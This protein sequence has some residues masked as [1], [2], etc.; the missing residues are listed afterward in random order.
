[1]RQLRSIHFFA[2]ILT[3][4]LFC[5]ASAVS[6]VAQNRV[7]GAISNSNRVPLR[8]NTRPLVKQ[9]EDLGA[10][11][12][13]TKLPSI[14]L[15]FQPSAGQQAALS[16]LLLE[17]QE[18]ASPMYHQWLTP[19]QFGA[20]FGASQHD[21]A[22]VSAW[23][24]QQGFAINAV[25]RGGQWINFAGTA[26]QAQQ[27]FG[28]ELHIIRLNGETHIANLT[29]PMIPAALAGVVSAIQGLDDFRLQP[30]SIV[31]MVS[32]DYTSSVSGSHY[33]APGDFYAI[34]DINPLLSTGINGTG[35]TIAVMGQVD[36]NL[37]DV[38][39]FR[40]VSG[41]PAN[42]PTVRLYGKD[43]GLPGTLG[44]GATTGDLTEAQLDVEWSGAVAPNASILFVNSTDAFTS[45]TNA[46]NDN[47]APILSVS[48]GNCESSFGS[49][50][51]NADN[52]LFEQA[53]AQGQS[54]VAPAG[55]SGA[56]DCDGGTDANGNPI[57]SATNGLAVDFPA[58]SP[59]VTGVGGATL[60]EGSGNYWNANNGAN[61]GSAIS[62]IP[63]VVW[64]DTNATNGL[65]A[66]GGGVSAFFAKP[67][68]QRGQ[69]VPNDFSRDVPDI[70]L[71]ASPNHDGYIICTEN[72]SKNNVDQGSSCQN[73][74]YR[75]GG[76][77][78]SIYVVGGTSAGVP[79][80]AGVLALVVQKT[81]GRIG[82]ANPIIYALA[83]TN[84]YNNI[85]HDITVGTNASP[86]TQG[87]V[88]CPNGGTLGYGATVGYDLASGWGSINAFNLA[89]TWSTASVAGIGSQ[90]LSTTTLA[91]SPVASK[92]G[93]SL[94]FTATVAPASGSG[95]PTGSVQFFLVSNGGSSNTPL[96]S[97]APLSNGTAVYSTT[98]VP[99]G[100]QT[101]GAF[102]QGDNAYG[103]SK[104]TFDIAVTS[105]SN[106][107]FSI[108]PLSGNLTAGAPGQPTNAF[109]LTFTSVN[110][111]AGKLT[112]SV[113]S[114]VNE[115]TYAFG[116]NATFNSPT[117]TWSVS[118]PANGS[119]TTT[120]T[121]GTTAPQAR[122]GP[123]NSTR[124]APPPDPRGRDRRL[125]FGAVGGGMVLAGMFLIA[126]PR[127][128][129]W[130]PLLAFGLL[131]VL[132][133]GVGC[134]GG[135]GGGGAGVTT[136]IPPNPGTSVGSFPVAVTATIAS[137]NAT[138]T[139]TANLTLVV[140]Q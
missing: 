79:S 6:A 24:Q 140:V 52:L 118:I 16:E 68:W 25:S 105:A 54:I 94:T 38:A 124:L 111:L 114:A 33:L 109:P 50:S 87:S 106:P 58:S 88:G 90:T 48:Y 20:Q 65:S 32:P 63:E 5:Q 37:A 59:Y 30:R 100:D 35:V 123:V 129:R 138:V 95:T 70:A 139:H 80:F 72:Y 8:G 4:L 13:G 83:N 69:G 53:A 57:T 81:G 125:G 62:Y 60:N 136:G 27:A 1:M 85:F 132:G 21:V 71:A 92:Q 42:A 135:Y 108:S 78:G 89:N 29:D 47:V 104:G 82:A 67:T 34:Y 19:E 15:S 43:P 122:R 11:P 51:I 128:R 120:L 9:A 66:G 103:T 137:G 75:S 55:D 115:Y 133:F 3:A 76:T 2:E 18:P 56:T 39:T 131:A 46:I 130:T 22:A 77:N 45:L 97:P 7:T 102:Y 134:G 119:V 93:A 26:A 14:T 84:M 12:A 28:T 91:V 127:R 44:N 86:C 61:Q 41:L 74:T 117:H 112:L 116:S 40:K 110:G 98:S 49:S 23:L 36:L 17:Q 31:H 10:A 96:G 113:S 73:G 101:V 126:S 64:N 107:D 99:A 121:M